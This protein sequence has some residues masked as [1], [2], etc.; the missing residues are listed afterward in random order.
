MYGRDDLAAYTETLLAAISNCRSELT[1]AHESV[2]GDVAVVTGVL[3]QQYDLNG[4]PE[5]V[6]MPA[7]F[8]VRRDDDRWR[9]CLF[10]ALPIPG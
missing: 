1:D 10:H 2:V 4:E 9:I 8:V 3:R 6:E 7:T 5:S